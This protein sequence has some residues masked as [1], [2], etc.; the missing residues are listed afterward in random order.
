MKTFLFL[1]VL[2]LMGYSQDSTS[3]SSNWQF[4]EIVGTGKILSSKLTV[5]IDYGQNSK[6]GQDNRIV[7]ENGK[8]ISFNSMVDAMNYMANDGWEFCQAYVVSEPGGL[9]GV[10]NVYRWLMKIKASPDQSGEL[11]PLTKSAYRKSLKK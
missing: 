10:Q 2:P 5:T 1:I 3:A 8:A 6:W 4:S 11:I 7:G 9:G